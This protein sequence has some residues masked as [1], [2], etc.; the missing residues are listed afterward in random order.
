MDKGR[1]LIE[2]HLR[3]GRP[4]AELARPTGCIAA[5]STSAWP[6]TGLRGEAGLELR[7]QP[8]P[9]PHRRRIADLWEDEIVGLRKELAEHGF[10]AGAATIQTH[11]AGAT[12][13]SR[14][15]RPSGGC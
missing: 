8:A 7:V 9:R 14:R 15:S 4:I 5:G 1:F 11:L 12:S 2:T 6:A 13:R 3:T 10:D